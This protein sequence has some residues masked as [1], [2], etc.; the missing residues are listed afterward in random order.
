MS[1]EETTTSEEDNSLPVVYSPYLPLS[2]AK[3]KKYTLVLDL[4][5]TLIHY[6]EYGHN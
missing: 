1:P 4:D 6:F 5:E 2:I 3:G